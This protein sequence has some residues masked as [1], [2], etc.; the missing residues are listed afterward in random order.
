MLARAIGRTATFQQRK[1][2]LAVADTVWDTLLAAAALR[3]EM[4]W[5]GFAL[6][7]GL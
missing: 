4:A 7:G 3:D 5:S 6:E 1:C 2:H